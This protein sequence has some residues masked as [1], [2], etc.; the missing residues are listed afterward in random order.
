MRH[1]LLISALMVTSAIA[2]TNVKARYE[3]TIAGFRVGIAGLEGAFSE[4]AYQAGVSVK[5]SGIA[6]MMAAG[7]GAVET[8]GRFLNGKAQPESYKLV[9]NAGD[10]NENIAISFA[11]NAV[12]SL[13]A[14]PN[15]PASTGTIPVTTSHKTNVLDPLSSGIFTSQQDS[16]EFGT[17]ACVKNFPVFD[18]RQRYDMKFSYD[19]KESIRAIG[20][21]GDAIICKARYVPISG[22]V[23]GRS[24]IEWLKNNQ[25]MEVWLVPVKGTKSFIPARMKI[26]TQMGMAVIEP[27]KLDLG[28]AVAAN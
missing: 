18:G 12:R 6:K 10:K 11:G 13:S 15:R 1:S 16:A 7:T 17:D 2:D 19:R 27:V 8:E 21:R 9:L 5:L 24:D 3:I 26:D 4:S 25:N 14:E 22:H 23:A 28:G 20:Y